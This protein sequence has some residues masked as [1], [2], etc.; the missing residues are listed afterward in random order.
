MLQYSGFSHEYGIKLIVIGDGESKS[1]AVDLKKQPFGVMFQGSFP[2]GVMVR[3]A[4]GERPTCTIDSQGVLTLTYQA[5]LSPPMEGS[6]TPRSQLDVYLLYG[7]AAV[8][9]QKKKA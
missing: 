9:E 8:T 7:A 3:N 5:P 4:D 2:T 6:L 1:L